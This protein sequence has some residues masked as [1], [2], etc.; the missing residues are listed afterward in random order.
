MAEAIAKLLAADAFEAYSAGTDQKDSINPD[1]VKTIRSLYGVD[2][3]LSQKPK[4]LDAIPPVDIVIT[5]GC[6]VQC[7]F[8]PCSFREDWGLEDPTGK[9]YQEFF[10]TAKTIETK[11]IDLKKRLEKGE[12][13]LQKKNHSVNLHE[14]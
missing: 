2:M 13:S 8:L 12:I 14:V 9:K 11:V 4:L 1:A 5:M 3:S 6:N 10:Q 7:P